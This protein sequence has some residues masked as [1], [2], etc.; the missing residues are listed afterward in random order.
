MPDLAIPPEVEVEIA[1]K[2]HRR[3]RLLESIVEPVYKAVY[4]ANGFGAL[5]HRGYVIRE[6]QRPAYTPEQIDAELRDEHERMRDRAI[7]G[8]PLTESHE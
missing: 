2:L 7:R 1:A 4:R 3:R 8:V 6:P 5:V